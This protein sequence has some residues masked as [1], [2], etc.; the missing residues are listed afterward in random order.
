MKNA[1]G[2]ITPTFLSRTSVGTADFFLIQLYFN[3]A[4][5]AFKKKKEDILLIQ[6]GLIFL[7]RLKN[8]VIKTI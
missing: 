3:D 2:E 4:F 7:V 6:N 5:I 8:N 1:L